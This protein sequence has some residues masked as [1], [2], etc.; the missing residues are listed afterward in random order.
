MTTFATGSRTEA[1]ERR[2]AKPPGRCG[3]VTTTTPSAPPRRARRRCPPSATTPPSSRRPRSRRCGRGCGSWPRTTDHLAEPGDYFEYRVGPYSV[4]IVHGND[5]VLRAFQNVCRHRGNALCV[6]SGIGP[7]RAQV[8]LPRL[9]LGPAGML[10]RVPGPQGLRLAAPVGLPAAAG[11]G[12]HL[13]ELRL[14]QH[15]HRRD[16]ARRVPRGDARRHRVG[17][18]VATSTAPRR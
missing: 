5:G 17:R 3:L 10:R 6:G 4:L 14:H 18:P 2:P 12:R 15:G 1:L 13:G 16:P 9:D 7:E 11:A 8:R